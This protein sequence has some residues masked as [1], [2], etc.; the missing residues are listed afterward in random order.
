MVGKSETKQLREAREA[1]EEILEL[2][3]EAEKHRS[4]KIEFDQMMKKWDNQLSSVSESMSNAKRLLKRTQPLRIVAKHTKNMIM[5]LQA[6]K[7]SL[8]N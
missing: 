6:K 8:Q 7:R 5:H 4:E 1:R 2:K 3:L